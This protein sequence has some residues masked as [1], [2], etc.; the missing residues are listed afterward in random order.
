VIKSANQMIIC[1]PYKGNTG[2]KAKI[3]SGVAVVQQKTEVVGLK[4][5]QDTEIKD[6]LIIKKNS[7]IYIKEE[8]L[9][10]HSKIYATPLSC[11]EFSVP[12]VLAHYSHIAFIKE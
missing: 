1:E 7:I 11:V 4:V 9:L 5:L 6:G 10:T 12:F 3:T 2:L 8:V